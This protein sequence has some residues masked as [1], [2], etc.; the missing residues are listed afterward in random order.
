MTNTKFTI[1]DNPK[2]ALRRFELP[3]GQYKSTVH[4]VVFNEDQTKLT[5]KFI[6]VDKDDSDFEMLVYR[7][8]FTS[9]TL[10]G[11]FAD[12]IEEF[13]GEQETGTEI[14]F[15]EVIGKKVWLAI[16]PIHKGENTYYNINSIKLRKKKK[17]SA[18]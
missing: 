16:E 3:A 5:L 1:P 9:N 6:V 10:K 11:P 4:A 17:D 8:Y 7:T 15:A 13:F 2:N 18:E 14:D 12:M